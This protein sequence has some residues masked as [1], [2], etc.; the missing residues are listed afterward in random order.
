VNEL[1]AARRAGAIG[2]LDL[3]AARFEGAG[4]FRVQR[5]RVLPLT[6]PAPAETLR[7][8]RWTGPEHLARVLLREYLYVA[9]HETLLDAQAAEHGK[10]LVVAETARSWLEEQLAAQRRRIAALRRERATQDVLEVAAGARSLRGGGGRGL[11]P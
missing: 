3:V 11:A 2:G 6:P 9:L 8:S 5:V 10:R 7:A 1:L 4:A